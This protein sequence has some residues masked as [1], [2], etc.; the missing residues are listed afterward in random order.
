MSKDA[1]LAI[2]FGHSSV[3]HLAFSCHS[4]LGIRHFA[5]HVHEVRLD[6]HARPHVLYAVDDHPLSLFQTVRD[7][8]E[9]VVQGAGPHRADSHLVLLAHALDALLAPARAHCSPP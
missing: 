3:G 2:S 1:T 6:S 5:R 9:A 8:P 4:S 7:L